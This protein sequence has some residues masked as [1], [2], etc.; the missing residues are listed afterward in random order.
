M[1]KI[2]LVKYGEISLKGRNRH[3]F[4]SML[5]DN[6]CLATG[7]VRKNIKHHYGRIYI[8][9]EENADIV[10]YEKALKKVF[11][12]VG[13]AIAY[14]LPI[15][16]RVD[17]LKPILTELLQ[18][19]VFH[20]IQT[21]CVDTRRIKKDFP[22]E[23]P[24]VNS[25]LGGVVLEKFPHWQ[26]NIKHPDLRIC[27]EIRPEGVFIYL[28]QN[29]VRGPG[30]LPIGVSGKGLLL[31]SGGI[32]SPVAGWSLMK[33]GMLI[34]AI[35]FHSFPYTG[36]KAKEKVIDLAKVLAQWKLRPVQLCIPYFTKIQETIN[37]QCPEDYWTILHRR[38]M[39]RIA[40][41]IATGAGPDGHYY[42]AL[43]TGDNLGQVASQTIHNIAAVSA[44]THLPILRPLISFDKQEII[45]LAEKIGTYAIS[46]RPFA[47]CC[48]L[49][50]PKNPQTKSIPAEIIAAEKYLDIESLI[51]ESLEKMEIIKV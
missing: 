48:T 23:S 40:E 9:L 22:L 16:D 14:E 46:K 41:K 38:M 24:Q 28:E 47:D 37:A 51:T 29:A 49:F 33:R 7:L 19:Q 32:D 43:I 2:I 15:T 4:E 5:L 11:G 25:I 44:A 45:T 30:G 21:F 31:L 10:A 12:I 42:Q 35:Y 50:A 8:S 26:V 39:V 18:K 6:I 13:F 1:K 20:S 3:F 17:D 34:D 36:E 27:L